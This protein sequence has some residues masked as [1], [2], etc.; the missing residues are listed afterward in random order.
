MHGAYTFI[1]AH[2]RTNTHSISLFLFSVFAHVLTL[3]VP[4]SL[5]LF[6]FDSLLSKHA[7][8]YSPV[9]SPPYSFPFYSTH[10]HMHMHTRSLP[11]ILS[12]PCISFI[13]LFT[14]F[15]ATLYFV[16]DVVSRL[17]LLLSY[18]YVFVFI[19]IYM[20]ICTYV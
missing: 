8:S 16:V 11:V 19:Y 3:L 13:L 14:L 20:Y 2:T 18:I 9:L 15:L 4:F 17:H 1:Y 10:A 6:L 7:L 12:F 5:F